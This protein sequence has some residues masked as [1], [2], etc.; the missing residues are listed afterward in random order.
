MKFLLAIDGSPASLQ[1]VRW[2][3]R[4]AGQGLAC[5]YVLVNVQEPPTLYEVVTAHDAG[6]I[7][8]VRAAAGADLLR[9]AEA[10]LTATGVSW[11]S[12]VA[13]GTPASLIVELA[14]NYGCDAIVIGAQGAGAAPGAGLG[15]VA[16]D[17]LAR[18]TLPVTVVPVPDDAAAAEV[19]AEPAA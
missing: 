19:T 15:R 6:T 1:A 11:E 9:E 5:E 16:L 18:A 7:D 2:A 14:E 17:V 3:L 12:E 8:E 10:L 13:G 4:Q